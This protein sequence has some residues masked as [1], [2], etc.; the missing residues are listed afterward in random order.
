MDRIVVVIFP[1]LDGTDRI[2]V[3]L[4]PLILF[5]QKQNDGR[6]IK[7]K[8][9]NRVVSEPALTII[10]SLLSHHH[11][12]HY[13]KNNYYPSIHPSPIRHHHHHVIASVCRKIHNITVMVINCP[14]QQRHRCRSKC[15]RN[16]RRAGGPN[17]RRRPTKQQNT[18]VETTILFPSIVLPR[19]IHSYSVLLILSSVLVF[20]K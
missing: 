16:R 5:L 9:G 18:V 7:I 2:V 4:L 14:Y 15:R 12:C 8:D 11:H 19:T 20:N 1:L 6:E 3:V 17:T 13:D 10:L